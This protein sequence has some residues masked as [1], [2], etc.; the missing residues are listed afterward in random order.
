MRRT[1]RAGGSAR[2]TRTPYDLRASRLSRMATTPRS[3]RERMRRPTPCLSCKVAVGSMRSLNQSWPSRFMR[4]TRVETTGSSGTV[5][6]MRSITTSDR[7][8]PTTSTPS[9]KLLV[10]KSTAA[11][12]VAHGVGL[13]EEGDAVH[14]VA[15]AG[16]VRGIGRIRGGAGVG[17]PG[18]I[19]QRVTAEELHRGGVVGARLQVLQAG[20]GIG[21]LPGEAERRA[22]AAGAG[23]QLAVGVIRERRHGLARAVEQAACAAQ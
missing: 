3:A 4:A 8:S 17:L 6:G 22:D 15:Q 9:Q 1:R 20:L 7:A 11:P 14:V 12:V 23:A 19:H 10:P 18:L 2:I 5:N 21:V 16:G 13:A